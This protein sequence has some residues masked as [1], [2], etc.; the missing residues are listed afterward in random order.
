MAEIRVQPKKK[1]HGWVWLLLLLVVVAAVVYY[2]YLNGSLNFAS[3][4]AEGLPHLASAVS[5]LAH[6]GTGGH[7]GTA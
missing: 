4:P 5:T 2:L 7:H 6:I 1:N 3:A